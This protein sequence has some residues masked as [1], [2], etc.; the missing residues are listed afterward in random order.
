MYFSDAMVSVVRVI[1]QIFPINTKQNH[2]IAEIRTCVNYQRFLTY[3]PIFEVKII[4]TTFQALATCLIIMVIN[5]L[6]SH[7]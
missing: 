1:G 7:H 3:Q 4:A 2:S 5:I 6:L